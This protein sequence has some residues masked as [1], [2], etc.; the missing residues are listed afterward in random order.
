MNGRDVDSK[1]RVCARPSMTW[2]SDAC[3]LRIPA[4]PYKLRM[5]SSVWQLGAM[6]ASLVFLRLEV[7]PCLAE[8][9]RS[10][11]LLRSALQSEF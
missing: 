3:K 8:N 5:M 11:R 2:L 4:G 7:M 9:L 6:G 10:P 1:Q